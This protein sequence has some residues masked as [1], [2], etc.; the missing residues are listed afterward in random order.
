MFWNTDHLVPE[1]ESWSYS[2][3]LF[4][5]SCPEASSLKHE[6]ALHQA[7]PTPPVWF[8]VSVSMSLPN[9]AFSVCYVKGGFFPVNCFHLLDCGFWFWK[10]FSYGSLLELSHNSGRLSGSSSC[11][12]SSLLNGK[13]RINR[14]K[15]CK[16]VVIL[17]VALI[18]L[19]YN[20]M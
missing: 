7:Q 11:S 18:Q 5:V 15:V 20:D 19:S 8:R 3:F 13:I 17:S 2:T 10:L 1:Y 9:S 16:S 14:S 12:F 6:G 4:A